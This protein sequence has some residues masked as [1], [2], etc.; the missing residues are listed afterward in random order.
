[1][2][3]VDIERSGLYL[4]NTFLEKAR[5]TAECFSRIVYGKF[6]LEKF[7]KCKIPE[8]LTR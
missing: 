5:L 8:Y 1:M 2:I 4:K 6:L 7:Y 3:V